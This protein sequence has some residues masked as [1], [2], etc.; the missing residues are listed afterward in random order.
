MA[1]VMGID[2]FN[3]LLND[4]PSSLKDFRIAVEQTCE[5][6][7]APNKFNSL[8]NVMLNHTNIP[9]SRIFRDDLKQVVP[10]AWPLIKSFKSAVNWRHVSDVLDKAKGAHTSLGVTMTIICPKVINVENFEI[11]VICIYIFRG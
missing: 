10:R 2:Y 3:T 5:T 1:L 6:I 9:Q 7:P 8:V 4:L 11:S